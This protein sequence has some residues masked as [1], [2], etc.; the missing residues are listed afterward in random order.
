VGLNL[1]HTKILINRN[2]EIIILAIS[3]IVAF[4]LQHFAQFFQQVVLFFKTIVQTFLNYTANIINRT[5]PSNNST[6]HFIIATEHSTICVNDLMLFTKYQML[7]IQL[8]KVYT[9]VVNS[10]KRLLKLS[11]NCSKHSAIYIH[12]IN[13]SLH[14]YY[15]N[16]L[17]VNI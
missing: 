1:S 5:A 2:I 10:T 3:Q 7:C 8:C 4:S 9:I 16:T 12:H 15:Y 11:T 6:F 13:T 14:K 17:T